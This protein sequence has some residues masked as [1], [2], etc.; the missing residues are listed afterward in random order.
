MSDNDL[1]IQKSIPQILVVDDELINR[2]ILRK[3]LSSRAQ[4]LEAEDGYQALE[5]A[6]S[7]TDLVLL[8]LMME[9]IDGIE[10]CR[11]LKN[12][13]DTQE[14]PVLSLIHI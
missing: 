14:V 13:P 12:R 5:R 11:R 8:D 2:S 4:I 3:F 10:V 9:G 7:E 1:Q 6:S